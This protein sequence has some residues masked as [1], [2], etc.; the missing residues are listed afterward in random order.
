MNPLPRSSHPGMPDDGEFSGDFSFDSHSTAALDRAPDFSM[1]DDFSMLDDSVPEAT[2]QTVIREAMHGGQTVPLR[3]AG[4]P[5]AVGGTPTMPLPVPR[6]RFRRGGTGAPPPTV[7]PSPTVRETTHVGTIMVVAGGLIAVL[8]LYLAFLEIEP[9]SIDPLGNSLIFLGLSLAGLAL[10]GIGLLL[11]IRGAFIGQPK[12]RPATA[13]VLA[14]IVMPLLL[15]GSGSMGLN[16]TKRSVQDSA[17]SGAGSGFTYVLNL[18]AGEGI[19][20]GPLA[21]LLD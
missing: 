18:M 15:V 9:V 8:A 16:E 3:V 11:A 17:I 13:I 2:T 4:D 10:C 20:I 14:L 6:G 21:G 19:N 1:P 5:A 7:A 12:H